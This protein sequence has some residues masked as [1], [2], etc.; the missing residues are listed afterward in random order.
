MTTGRI[1]QVASDTDQLVQRDRP[2]VKGHQHSEPESYLLR[3]KRTRFEN[4]TLVIGL[5]LIESLTIVARLESFSTLP[6]FT[7]VVWLV[8]L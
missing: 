4:E 5:K 3:Y 7:P 8:H 2:G 1:N 6:S